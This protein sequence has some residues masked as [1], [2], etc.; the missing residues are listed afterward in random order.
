MSR[1]WFWFLLL[2]LAGRAGAIEPALISVGDPWAFLPGTQEPPTHWREPAYDDSAWRRGESG[3][4]TTSRGENTRFIGLPRG[5]G[6]VYFRRP[7]VVSQPDEIQ[8]L[9]L[10]LDWQGGFV[11]SINGQEVLRRGLGAPGTWVAYTNY[12][13]LRVAGA[14]EEFPVPN[15]RELLRPGTNVISAQVHLANPLL[16]YDVVFVPELLA[17]WTRGPYVQ[18]SAPG[19]MDVL[20]RT[21]LTG[22][23][24]VEYGLT[25]ALGNAVSAGA[26]PA[27][28]FAALTNLLPGTRYFYR[29]TVATPG[30]DVSTPTYQFRTLPAAGPMTALLFGDSGSG[31]RS[32]FEV[33]REFRRQSATADVFVHLGDIVYPS[34]TVGQTD[35]RCLSVYRDVLRSLPSFFSWGNHD[36]PY[37]PTPYQSAF[38]MPTN[39]TPAL[40]HLED[41]TQPDFYYSFDAGDAHFA[42]LFWTFS[43]QYYMRPDCPQLRWLEADLTASTKRWK[44][45]CLHHP[46][47]T[48][49]LHRADN[50]NANSTADRLEVAD[51]LLPVAQRHRVQAI[52]SGHDHDYERFQPVAGVH[53]LVSGGGGVGLYGLAEMDPNSACFYLRWHLTRLE[54]KEDSLRLTALGT[55]GGPIDVLEFRDTPADSGDADGDGLGELAEVL[56]G[57]DPKRPDTDGDGLPD[58]W[59]FLRGMDPATPSRIRSPDGSTG[60]GDSTLLAEVLAEPIPRPRTELRVHALPDGR[61]QLRWLAAVGGRIQAEAAATP[62]GEFLPLAG[63]GAPSPV[64]ADRQAL[65]LSTETTARYF[66]VRLLSD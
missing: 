64:A 22:A 56:S 45:L 49:G 10:R 29:T 15:F 20:W 8:A 27:Y 35:T 6:T 12:A 61:I 58:G 30:G 21:P 46:V 39:T 25:A 55:D 11:V 44:F 4:G 1:C 9:V 52:F 13:E 2:T 60:P 65:E 51:R 28:A 19:G 24:R 3:F 37:G 41:R 38:R 50:Y 33:A 23:A 32:Q 63:A 5:S 42:V 40:D 26:H 36:L 14:A 47:N 54:V 31:A 17:N 34:L 43:S 48:S 59:E 57:S 18:P 7:F 53:T 16:G 66:R 62:D